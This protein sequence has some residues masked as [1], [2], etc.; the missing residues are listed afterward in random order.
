MTFAPYQIDYNV[1]NTAKT[2]G[3]SKKKVIFRFGIANPESIRPG[4]GLS[5]AHCRGSEH[6]VT[7]LWSL[8]TGKRQLL[9]DNKDV[10]FSESGQN[11]WTTDRAWQ[12]VFHV[13]DVSTGGNFRCHFISQP[14]NKE[15][16]GSIPFDLRVS[17]VSYFSF[18]QIFQLGTAAMT[19]REQ[20]REQN[21]H[22][23]HGHHSGRDSPM[24]PEE[25]RAIANAKAESLREM[26]EYRENRGRANTQTTQQ[27]SNANMNREEASLI[28]FDEPTPAPQIATQGSQGQYQQYASSLT[29]DTVID[30]RKQPG[31]QT[32]SSTGSGGGWN[33]PMPAAY[34]QQQQQQPGNS[35]ALTAY[36]Q[37]G[38]QP[39]PYV[40]GMGRM[41]MGQQG[42]Q[43]QQVYGGYPGQQQGQGQQAMMSPSG[44]SYVSQTSYGSAPSFAQP[45]RQTP[46]AAASDRPGPPC[47]ASN[48]RPE[49]EEDR[50]GAA[51]WESYARRRREKERHWQ[52]AVPR[53]C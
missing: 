50:Q 19:T 52:E 10:H 46:A 20:S 15:V 13:R 2:L 53:G 14:V 29:L 41:S 22:Q 6:E 40:D 25:R 32:P 42:Q 21:A 37:P 18:N 35:M 51:E 8:K 1:K 27:A 26:G 30:D 5:G 11:G 7:F 48:W 49:L 9:V 33:Q 43:Q 44:Q 45:P 36:Q 34:G 31:Q 28:S 3:F 16:P 38:G 17:G 4:S 12:H 24:S 39:A 23:G 47:A